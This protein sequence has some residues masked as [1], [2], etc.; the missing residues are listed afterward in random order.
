MS[1]FDQASSFSVAER[2]RVQAL[3]EPAVDF[4]EHSARFVAASSVTKEPSETHRRAQ[5]QRFGSLSARNLNR[6]LKADLS[7]RGVGIVLL[8]QRLAYRAI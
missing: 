2:G 3:G 4:A 7:F 6:P 1:H 5:F 8:R